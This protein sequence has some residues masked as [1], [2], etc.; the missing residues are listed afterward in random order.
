[1]ATSRRIFVKWNRFYEDTSNGMRIKQKEMINKDDD[2][3][4]RYEK[5]GKRKKKHKKNSSVFFN[6]G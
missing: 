1:M 5:R 6:N 3:V 4:E 2:D